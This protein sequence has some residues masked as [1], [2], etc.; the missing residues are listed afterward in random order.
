MI[1]KFKDGSFRFY[2]AQYGS[3]KN[4]QIIVFRV[5][6]DRNPND[7]A[8]EKGIKYYD[9]IVRST[10]QEINEWFVGHGVDWINK[11]L[12]TIDEQV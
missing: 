12:E 1:Y 8:L 11:L 5:R 6:I 2:T 10:D 9:R 4:D 7:R 3:W